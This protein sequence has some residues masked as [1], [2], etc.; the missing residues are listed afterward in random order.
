MF[1]FNFK[2]VN[3]DKSIGEG[4][5]GAIYPYQKSPDDDK[6]VVKHLVTS[7]ID[8]MLKHLNEIVL[9]FSCD[10]P[11]VLPIKGYHINFGPEQ[12]NWNIYLKMERMKN[13]SLKDKIYSLARTNTL[14]SEKEVI[15]YFFE[16]SS[17]LAYLHNRK[18]THKDIK[19]DNILIDSKGNLKI[20]DIGIGE[21]LEGET[22]YNVIERAGTPSYSAPEILDD[23]IQLV[24]ADLLK[25]DAWSL[26]VVMAEI[27]L[28]KFKP[29]GA[30]LLGVAKETEFHKQLD[31]VKGRYGVELVELIKSL[32]QSDRNERK[33][34]EEV[35]FILK[36]KYAG[37]LVC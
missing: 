11:N 30:H 2:K 28:M 19:P 31:E 17:G 7:K 14:L 32:L 4:G 33:T 16:I 1:S 12:K 5:W 34:V 27:C 37:I 23:R 25:A 18:I 15:Q 6:W 10:H 21:L 26:G 3:F 36:K 35:N 13:G 29:V 8:E 9:G 22:L 20:A 24:K